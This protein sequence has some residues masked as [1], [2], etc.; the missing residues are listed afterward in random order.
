MILCWIRLYAQPSHNLRKTYECDKFHEKPLT[1]V[2]IGLSTDYM[3]SD[4]I[5][6][7]SRRT[8]LQLMV[9]CLLV[10]AALRLP[11]LTEVPPGLH[12]D[13]AA[14]GLLAQEVGLG[15]ERPI[16]IA[17]YTGK[18]TLFFYLAGGLMRVSG[19][20]VFTLRLTS[21]YLGLLTVAVT[22]W[23]GT[24]LLGDGVRSTPGR[25]GEHGAAAHL[26]PRSGGAFR[27]AS[28]DRYG[29]RARPQARGS[30]H[31]H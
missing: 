3:P 18:E 26:H 7:M 20:S 25:S 9:L 5:T 22:F 8:A 10:A 28:G 4:K 16:F 29:L 21:A 13:E 14:N 19:P 12:Y 11:K 30:P 15:G 27:R 1:L 17:S 23:M 24:E 6:H 2:L 31:R